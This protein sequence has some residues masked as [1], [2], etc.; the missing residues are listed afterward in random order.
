V[1]EFALHD[2]LKID[3]LGCRITKVNNPNTRH[4][5]LLFPLQFLYEDLW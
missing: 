2:A 4:N 3:R 5:S 1:T